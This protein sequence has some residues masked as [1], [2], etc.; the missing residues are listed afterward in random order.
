MFDYKL[1]QRMK[2]ELLANGVSE[3]TAKIFWSELRNC[4]I[5]SIGALSQIA[6]VYPKVGS[7]T[8]VKHSKRMTRIALS[9]DNEI[10]QDFL[11]AIVDSTY[12]KPL[13]K[14]K[15]A[16]D[17]VKGSPAKT[18]TK[19]KTKGFPIIFYEFT[20]QD[21]ENFFD[22]LF[23][24]NKSKSHHSTPPSLDIF[25]YLYEKDCLP[26]SVRRN[27]VDYV[28]KRKS[29]AP[30]AVALETIANI[31]LRRL[32]KEIL[33]EDLLETEKEIEP[34]ENKAA[35]GTYTTTETIDQVEFLARELQKKG[36]AVSEILVGKKPKNRANG[37]YHVFVCLRENAQI[38]VAQGHFPWIIREPIDFENGKIT[39]ED[40]K[41]NPMVYMSCG[42]L[43]DFSDTWVNSI[44]RYT[45]EDIS[46][47]GVQ[48]KN[49][50]TWQNTAQDFLEAFKAAVK[51]EGGVP[52]KG[53]TLIKS[54]NPDIN[55][56]RWDAGLAQLRSGNIIGLAHVSAT[57]EGRNS[58]STKLAFEIFCTEPSFQDEMGDWLQMRGRE[59]KFEKYKLER[60]RLGSSTPPT[61]L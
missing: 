39:V 28:R 35:K 14:L 51:E 7:S 16:I 50:T 27:F 54:D 23:K 40:L 58:G 29:N 30:K 24:R 2:A 41:Q 57:E 61:P 48:N 12:Y 3:E 9:E 6:A 33:S 26:K 60:A 53:S 38:V 11:I 34:R 49:R 59:E 13:S 20:N 21:W 43:K 47:L 18:R 19:I 25:K 46:I 15:K 36:F 52:P 17:G 1:D 32:S 42:F 55:G 10:G 56:K 8:F 4:T 5:A 31:P 44:I 37:H 22:I 45:T